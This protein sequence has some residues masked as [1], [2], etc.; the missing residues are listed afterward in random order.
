M[1]WGD[2]KMMDGTYCIFKGVEF[3][4]NRMHNTSTPSIVNSID[5]QKYS[6]VKYKLNE[7]CMAEVECYIEKCLVLV[8]LPER[9]IK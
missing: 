3:E 6:D 7:I 4:N 5:K 9:L 2:W 8:I 1:R